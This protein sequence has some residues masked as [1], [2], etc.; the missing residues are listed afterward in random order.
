[1]QL[2]IC[3][4]LKFTVCNAA[5]MHVFYLSLSISVQLRKPRVMHAALNV[6]YLLKCHLQSKSRLGVES[7]WGSHST[8]FS[9]LPYPIGLAPFYQY[10]VVPDLCP[11]NCAV[12]WVKFP[13]AVFL[14]LLV[15]TH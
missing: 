7:R 13:S 3:C 8:L 12:C 5:I 15:R 6:G 9:V 11:A 1:M 14:K 4:S 10:S 2:V